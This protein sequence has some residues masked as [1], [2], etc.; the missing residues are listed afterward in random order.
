MLFTLRTT[1]HLNDLPKING[2]LSC[3]L[4]HVIATL[5]E[6]CFKLDQ[7]RWKHL[8][9]CT[10]TCCLCDFSP[11]KYNIRILALR[12]HVFQIINP[13]INSRSNIWLLISSLSHALPA[14]YKQKSDLMACGSQIN[15]N[16]K[17][18][19]NFYL[20]QLSPPLFQYLSLHQSF[21]F[22]YSCWVFI[23]Y[24]F[25]MIMIILAL[26]TIPIINKRKDPQININTL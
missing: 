15:F 6:K 22:R 13:N 5:D 12:L 17:N 20:F 25:L 2:N 16:L 24:I 18:K 8:I 1:H 10:Q 4:C 21:S 14:P 3:T 11:L 9:W 23:S 26:D 19:I 7:Q